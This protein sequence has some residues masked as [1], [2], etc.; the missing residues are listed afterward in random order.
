M[1]QHLTDPA[2]AVA[3]IAR[4]L[5]PGGRVTLLDTD[6][7][8]FVLHPASPV[9]RAALATVAQE[10]AATPDAGR[11]LAEWSADAGL[12]V[13]ETGSDVLLH[14][15]RSVTWPL[16]HVLGG[17]AVERGLI[18]GAQRDGLYGGLASAAGRGAFHLSVTMFAVLAHRPRRR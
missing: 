15:P 12:T 16:V 4:V 17:A 7:A 9:V 3:E 6:W 8:T 18:T 13:D 2:R 14:D 11:R 5:R 1:L 10:T